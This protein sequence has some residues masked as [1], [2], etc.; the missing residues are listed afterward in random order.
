MDDI[1]FI[2]QIIETGDMAALNSALANCDKSVYD[3]LWTS[4]LFIKDVAL[5]RLLVQ[6]KA[7]VTF[8]PSVKDWC[9]TLL[10]PDYSALLKNRTFMAD[11]V[12]I[13]KAEVSVKDKSHVKKLLIGAVAQGC[14]PGILNEI[15]QLW[16]TSY[17]R[18]HLFSSNLH[19]IRTFYESVQQAKQVYFSCKYSMNL[20]GLLNKALFLRIKRHI[21]VL[22]NLLNSEAASGL[23]PERHEL[24]RLYR[25]HDNAA[26]TKRN[27]ESGNSTR[28]LKYMDTWNDFENVLSSF[29]LSKVVSTETS[30]KH[31]IQT[32]EKLLSLLD[33]NRGGSEWDMVTSTIVDVITDSCVELS[34]MIPDY[35]CAPVLV[36][37]A[38]EGTRWFMPNE[39]D[40]T[41]LFPHYEHERW[42]RLDFC[43]YFSVAFVKQ[44]TKRSTPI[45]D[46]FMLMDNGK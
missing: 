12:R 36:G 34:S 3:E 38:S 39:Y 23:R 6:D 30:K 5:F 35:A 18:K 19:F 46:D 27:L 32:V 4:V 41:L 37:N 14:K 42:S 33:N 17:S 45:A 24:A 7:C 13:M 28:D 26:L 2:D 29:I 11:V 44:L 20:R 22:W 16:F 15:D 1:D 8:M 9:E 31:A 40:F 10:D 43:E 21:H 25:Y